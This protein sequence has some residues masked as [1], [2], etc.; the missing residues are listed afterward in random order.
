MGAI[1]TRVFKSGNSAAVRL[2]VGFGMTPGTRVLIEQTNVGVTIKPVH[3]KA[4]AKQE[5]LQLIADL[6]AIWAEHG[7]PP[8]RPAERESFE[9][10]ERPGL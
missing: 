10:P 1:E 3:Y 7:G 5:L 4:A 9:M 8:E 2:P 6:Q